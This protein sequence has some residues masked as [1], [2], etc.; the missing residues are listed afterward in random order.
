VRLALT[1]GMG[2][3][4]E[5][6]A[7]ALKVIR[8][9]DCVRLM[10]DGPKIMEALRRQGLALSPQIELV[11]TCGNDEP[12]PVAAIRMAA[13]AAFR[14]EVDGMVTGPINK[15]ALV[16]Q[17]FS[18]MGHTDML[19]EIFGVAP[20]MAFT[21]G[22]LRVAL[23]T[24]HIPLS[25]VA[26][27]IQPELVAHTVRT[28][29]QALIDGL[30][31]AAPRL[32]LCGLNPHAGE[33]GL[34]GRCEGDVLAPTAALLRAEGIDVLG[35]IS[36]EAAFMLAKNGDFDLVVAMYHD[37]GLVPL[38]MLDFGRSVNWTLG[39]PIVRTSVDHGT[40]DALVGKSVADPSSMIAAIGLAT[41]LVEV[42]R[43]AASVGATA[44]VGS[45]ASVGLPDLVAIKSTVYR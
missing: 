4:F 19:G 34:L 18:C 22:V 24:T 45:A 20:V 28:A 29:H 5:V 35:P 36:A 16:A 39:L 41:K 15:A 1:P 12:A 10:G 9:V 38:K 6:T 25:A 26:A 31:I 32:A 11:D 3:G 37:Q 2:I 21:G 14:G 43:S 27:A 7:A 8:G 13:K 40:A 30:G 17:G 33:G 23:V 42:R 44:S